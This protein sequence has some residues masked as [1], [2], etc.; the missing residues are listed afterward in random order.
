MKEKRILLIAEAGVNHNGDI[1]IALELVDAAKQ[2]GADF[3]KF[4][5]FSSKAMV[6][7]TASLAEYQRQG[8]GHFKKSE[9]NAPSARIEL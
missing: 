9:R 3:V 2:A 5:T 1:S 8:V 4:Q 7:S 6:S